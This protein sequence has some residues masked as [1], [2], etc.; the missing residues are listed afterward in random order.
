MVL[1]LWRGIASLNLMLPKEERKALLYRLYDDT[2]ELHD[3]SQRHPSTTVK[4]EPIAEGNDQKDAQQSSLS[5][6]TGSG[7][8]QMIPDPGQKPVKSEDPAN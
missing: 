6:V 8:E 1:P 2:E 3:S 4:S 7:E 5:A